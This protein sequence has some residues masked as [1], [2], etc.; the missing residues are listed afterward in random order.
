MLD[1]VFLPTVPKGMKLDYKQVVATPD[2]NWT[3]VGYMHHNT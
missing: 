2:T 1:V 3:I